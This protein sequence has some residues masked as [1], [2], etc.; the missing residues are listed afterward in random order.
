MKLYTDLI[1]PNFDDK[2]GQKTLIIMTIVKVL[3]L[4]S[5][6]QRNNITSK[7]NGVE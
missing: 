3:Q 2:S 4:Y 7:S 1:L 5:I 6:L